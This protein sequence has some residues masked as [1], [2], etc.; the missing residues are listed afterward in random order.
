FLFFFFFFL[1]PASTFFYIEASTS[2]C[3]SDSVSIRLYR[4]ATVSFVCLLARILLFV[5]LYL[6]WDIFRTFIIFFVVFSASNVYYALYLYEFPSWLMGGKYCG[7]GR[8]FVFFVGWL[9]LALF[10]LFL[11]LLLFFFFSFGSGLFYL[12]IYVCAAVSCSVI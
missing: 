12:G 8:L 11:F 7:F 6:F 3:K 1:A 9:W 5:Q 10:L 2:F 4:S